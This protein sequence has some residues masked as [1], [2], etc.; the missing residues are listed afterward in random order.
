MAQPQ[1]TM[2]LCRPSCSRFDEATLKRKV[3]VRNGLKAQ[4]ISPKRSTQPVPVSPTPTLTRPIFRSPFMEINAAR[5]STKRICP[6]APLNL[7]SPAKQSAP[8]IGPQQNVAK[9]WVE[10]QD[11]LD[12]STD[13]Q[14]GPP[15]V[16]NKE[17][18]DVG[19]DPWE[20]VDQEH[21]SPD[22]TFYHGCVCKMYFVWQKDIIQYF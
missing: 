19:G 14:S 21:H 8:P 3:S 16:L 17:F 10:T 9:D 4:F 20:P 11:F 2:C 12:F 18:H 7:S 22:I 6:P 15:D 5:T 1:R 13:M